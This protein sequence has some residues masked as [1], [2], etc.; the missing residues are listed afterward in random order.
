MLT[1]A[2]IK[3]N[4]FKIMASTELYNYYYFFKSKNINIS[5]DGSV[6]SQNYHHHGYERLGKL[7]KNKCVQI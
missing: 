4:I 2:S 1:R 6:A 5:S 3:N 7:H